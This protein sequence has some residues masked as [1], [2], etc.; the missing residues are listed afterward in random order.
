MPISRYGI[1]IPSIVRATDK[2]WKKMCSVTCTLAHLALNKWFC[3]H[4]HPISL[5]YCSQ[6]RDEEELLWKKKRE[7]SICYHHY[8]LRTTDIEMLFEIFLP[9]DLDLSQPK[10]YYGKRI[11][12]L[13]HYYWLCKIMQHIKML[14]TISSEGKWLYMLSHDDLILL[15]R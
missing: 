12:N 14:L 8:W 5:I 3:L 2:I 1:P 4:F 11:E 13:C 9:S 6:T 15:N 7:D 10:N